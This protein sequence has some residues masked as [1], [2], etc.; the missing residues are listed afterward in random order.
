MLMIHLK[1]NNYRNSC[2]DKSI[3]IHKDII[4]L[5][6]NYTTQIQKKLFSTDFCEAD[7]NRYCVKKKVL[8]FSLIGQRIYIIIQNIFYKS[9]VLQESSFC[10]V[11][12]V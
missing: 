2:F 11:V 10:K 1:I 8:H 12:Q 5:R 4:L 7:I 9:T 3:N 6:L